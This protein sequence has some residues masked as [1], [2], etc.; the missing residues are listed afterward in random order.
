M[1][2]ATEPGSADV[3][4]DSDPRR[5]V[6]PLN[7]D[8]VEALLRDLHILERWRHVV[9]GLR[10]GFEVGVDVPLPRSF[11]F[12]NHASS[13][14]DEGFI[15][16]YIAAEIAAG[17]YSEGY[18]PR[19]LEE[20]IGP[21]QTSPLGLVPKAG[22]DTFRLV[23]D[24]SY[25]RNDPS[26][27]SVNAKINSDDFPTEW[28]TF[29]ETSNLI[30]QLPT[31]TL[32][33]AFD[34][35]A[36]YR[37]TPIRPEHQN[38]VCL[39]WRGKVYVDR[40]VMFGLSSSAGVFGA[41]ADML[42][43][44]YRASGFGPIRKWVDDFLAFRL[45]NQT[46]TEEDFIAL[47]ARLGVPWSAKKTKPLS[48]VQR[49]IGFIWD[50]EKKTVALPQEKLVSTVAM[51]EPWLVHGARFT[52]REAASLH[53]KLVHAATIFH[54]T[55]PF[56]RG[57]SHFAARFKSAR[58]RLHPP[59]PLVQDLVWIR[60]ML[61]VSPNTLPLALPTPLDLGWWGDASTSFGIG[62]AVGKYWAAWKWAP[63][64]RV[65]PGLPH[66]IG[67]AEATA[68]ELG[69]RLIVQY[70]LLAAVP[71]G[72]SNLLVR[73]DNN[74][75]VAVVNKGRSRSKATNTILKSIFAVLA[76]RGLR[77]TAEYVTSRDNVT[78]A[79]SRGDIDR[80]RRG[81]PVASTQALLLL[82][83]H[84]EEKLVSL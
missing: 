45:P 36:A 46:W 74:G 16:K 33:A 17:R 15:N 69:L 71:P 57:L 12:K 25:P 23:Q 52:A 49:Y 61:S 40:A 13:E 72:A 39:F 53:G 62:I 29:D 2:P 48:S 54:I 68:V 84:L 70:N 81:F 21:F 6:T 60:D 31:G 26:I 4:S 63:G 59:E 37:I 1:T 43:A 77:L 27:S 42:V 44:V 11:T 35:S 83:S 67:W 20:I 76:P 14:L 56:L 22:A 18:E 78:D 7:P 47:T 64:F 34:I 10:S 3:G 58:A 8:K 30:L 19:E 9:D 66:D 51:I 41:V 73:S 38:A 79:L 5:V 50:L 75:V 65:G 80:F 28:G 32:A 82:P 24:M 55:R